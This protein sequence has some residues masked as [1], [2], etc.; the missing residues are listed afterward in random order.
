MG[1]RQSKERADAEST[2]NLSAE[3]E[4]KYLRQL[5]E[6]EGLIAMSKYIKMT[7]NSWQ[8]EQV[9]IA[10]TGRSATGKSTFINTIR[11]VKPG[12]VGFA[13]TGSGDTTKAPTLYIHP[14]NDQ[15]TFC[16]LPGYSSTMFK[17]EDYISE[18]KISDYDFFLIFVNNALSEDDI[19][20]AG[21]LRKLDKPFSFV[22]SKIDVDIDN[23]IPDGKD[24]EMI[25]PEI[26][27]HLEEAMGAELEYTNCIFLISSRKPDL[28]EMSDL[29][30]Y[31]EETMDGFKAQVLVV[32]IHPMTKN[33]VERKHKL[34]KARL[35]KVTA[36]AAGIAASPLPGVDAAANFALLAKELDHYLHVF[37]IQPEF[38]NSL[39][40]FDRSLLKCKSLT[41]Q[42]FKMIPFI[43]SKLGYYA[44]VAV[45]QSWLEIML[46]LVGSIVS[47]A[48]ASWAT[49][50]FLDDML[51]DL[52]HDA[53]LIHGHHVMEASAAHRSSRI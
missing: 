50:T 29:I 22:R 30:R 46:P 2:D 16:D 44:T 6:K 11:N 23:A 42:T 9:K 53:M 34:L 19:W 12:D 31:I 1:Q 40:D 26:K 8:T 7:L 43:I 13:I 32:S 5:A 18:M 51:Q 21:E 38:V 48:T 33:I 15:I 35:V 10:I 17:K 45:T 49:Y 4:I 3:K 39:K 52:K 24:P 27:R 36:L 28:G 14:T 25:I 37:E 47:A 41:T 20:M